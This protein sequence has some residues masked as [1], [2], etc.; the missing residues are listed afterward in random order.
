MR[1]C[2]AGLVIV[3]SRGSSCG[4]ACYRVPL[5]NGLQRLLWFDLE[6][7]CSVLDGKTAEGLGRNVKHRVNHLAKCFISLFCSQVEVDHLRQLFDRHIDK[8][9]TF[10]KTHCKELVPITELNG[11]ASLCRLYDSLATPEN[12]VRTLSLQWCVQLILQLQM[13]RI[14]DHHSWNISVLLKTF[15]MTWGRFLFMG[16]L[17]L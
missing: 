12:G 3:W 16:K 9:L 13:D 11:V 6:A 8:T 1:E 2:V 10:K 15:R 4:I 5:W 17:V 14:T 7:L